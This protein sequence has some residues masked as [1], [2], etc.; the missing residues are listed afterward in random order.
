MLDCLAAE[1]LSVV[2]TLCCQKAAADLVKRFIMSRCPNIAAYSNVGDF[3]ARACNTH[4]GLEEAALFV[5]VKPHCAPNMCPW[6]GI[7]T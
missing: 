1:E 2:L 7:S 4:I 3:W 6:P 5:R